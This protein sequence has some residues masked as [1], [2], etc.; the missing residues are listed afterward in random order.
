MWK[1]IAAAFTVTCVFSH[2]ASALD[3]LPIPVSCNGDLTPTLGQKLQLLI[4][5]SAR[6]WQRDLIPSSRPQI[7]DA[8]HARLKEI[9]PPDFAKR[10][11]ISVHKLDPTYMFEKDP[12][13]LSSFKHA[14]RTLNESRELLREILEVTELEHGKE[15]VA[16]GLAH[17]SLAIFY[18]TVARDLGLVH[19]REAVRILQKVDSAYVIAARLHLIKHLV[20]AVD[21]F[22]KRGVYNFNGLPT[23]PESGFSELAQEAE[24]ELQSLFSSYM[25]AE[26]TPSAKAWI[27]LN[28]SYQQIKLK[29]IKAAVAERT[30]G[31][32]GD[33]SLQFKKQRLENYV[34]LL[35]VL[36]AQRTMLPA[37][38][39]EGHDGILFG[40]INGI[41]WGYH[42]LNKDTGRLFAFEQSLY[43]KNPPTADELIKKLAEL[44]FDIPPAASEQQAIGSN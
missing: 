6:R 4:P 18:F 25:H 37:M 14:V 9:L 28:A 24:S 31:K 44:G 33:L 2:P 7:L 32:R 35:N 26:I 3:H 34:G 17:Y 11:L 1:L 23:P 43:S 19:A 22:A 8:L 5:P 13:D 38:I 20:H 36:L 30:Q 42:D 39:Q 40:V 10:I 15:S 41:R 27:Y 21:L 29:E 16:A 12:T